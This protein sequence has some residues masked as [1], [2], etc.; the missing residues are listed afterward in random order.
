MYMDLQALGDVFYFI[1]E[2]E[3]GKLW[4]CLLK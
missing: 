4:T 2:T 1:L 3:R